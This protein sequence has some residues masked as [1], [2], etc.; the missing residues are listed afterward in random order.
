[1]KIQII[2]TEAGD[3]MVVMSRRDYDALLARAGDE[4]AED[5][6]TVLIA[7]ESRAEKPLPEPVSASVLAGDSVLK[8]LRRWRGQTQVEL[9]QAAELTQSYLSELEGGTK[10]GSPEALAKLAQALDV[11]AG[12]L[13]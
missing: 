1:M 7:A 6:M 5:R 8:A 13:G 4:D 12:W 2:E 11:P 3:E 10:T 9:A